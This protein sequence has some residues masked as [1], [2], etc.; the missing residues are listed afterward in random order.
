LQ[1]LILPLTG[2]FGL[3]L[4]QIILLDVVRFM[5]THTWGGFDLG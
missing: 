4:V 3:A 5:L 1:E 2:G